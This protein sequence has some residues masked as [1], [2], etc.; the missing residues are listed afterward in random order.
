MPDYPATQKEAWALSKYSRNIDCHYE[1]YQVKEN[2]EGV[3]PADLGQAE[4]VEADEDS[5]QVS[6]VIQQLQSA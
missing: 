4:E 6:S 1:I 5:E 3:A 2:E